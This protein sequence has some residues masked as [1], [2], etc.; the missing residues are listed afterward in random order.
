ML[1][2]LRVSDGEFALAFLFACLCFYYFSHLAFHRYR[3]IITADGVECQDTEPRV[4]FP[5]EV[6]QS[7]LLYMHLPLWYLVAKV[8]TSDA[9]ELCEL[10]KK[11]HGCSDTCGYRCAPGTVV[12]LELYKILCILYCGHLFSVISMTGCSLFWNFQMER[13][14][15]SLR[16]RCKCDTLERLPNY[17]WLGQ[18]PVRDK[19]YSRRSIALI[20]S[21]G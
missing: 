8:T 1:K 15:G 16:T 9:D 19:T 5:F 13:R 4:D 14:H 11:D 10:V 7:L 12:E 3:A 2:I 17:W 18:L 6:N 20:T 21:S